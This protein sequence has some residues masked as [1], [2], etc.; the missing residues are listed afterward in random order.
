MGMIRS[1]NNEDS[2][3]P[4]QRMPTGGRNQFRKCHWPRM[5]QNQVGEA[6]SVSLQ[7]LR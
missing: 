4:K 2:Q 3:L 6:S 1:K 7:N 5:L